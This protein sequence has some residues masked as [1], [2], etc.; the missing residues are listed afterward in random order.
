VTPRAR[1]ALLP[2]LAALPAALALRWPVL[3]AV[4]LGLDLLA[5]GL[6]L[7]GARGAEA[8]RAVRVVREDPG[9]LVSGRPASLQLTVAGTE[10]ARGTLTV[11]DRLPGAF[12]PRE[13]SFA[14]RLP[15]SGPV[16]RQRAFT[17]QRRGRFEL[18]PPSATISTPLGVAW[19]QA[20]ADTVGSLRVLPDLRALRRFDSLVR[21]RRLNEMGIVR[22][23]VR[24]EG[25][26]IAGL[27]AY[28]AGDPFSAI[29]W[30]ATARRGLLVARERQAERRQSLVLLLDTGRRMAREVDGRSRLDY[31]VE[32]ALLL[33]HV[34][35]RTDDRVGL[36][37]FADGPVRNLAPGRGIAQAQRLARAVYDLAPVPREPPYAA[38]AARVDQLHSRRSLMVLF[39]D[40]VE[41]VSLQQLAAPLRFLGRRHLC[42]CVIFQD[43]AIEAALRDPPADEAGLYRAGAAASLL[44]EREAGIRAL[45]Q[46]G[47]LVLEAP[48][49]RLSAAVVNQYLEIKA[50]QLL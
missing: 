13:G 50:R 2:L 18:L 35:L 49:D 27:R 37:A 32:A 47:A 14:L 42:L 24:G 40:A 25:S 34:A 45:R 3:G 20:G 48:P 44:R 39:T 31:A 26:E 9:W 43:G 21:Q 4:A 33:A 5:V 1:L 28:A 23:R 6:F 38:I 11:V 22:A 29:D 30:K 36:L 19:Q 12:E 15:A 7:W 17:P 46:T 10:A 41:S 16:V 8:R